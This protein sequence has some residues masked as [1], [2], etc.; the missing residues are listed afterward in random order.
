MLLLLGIIQL[1]KYIASTYQKFEKLYNMALVRYNK[2]VQAH[3]FP[4]RVEN[5]LDC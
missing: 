3:R 4:Q 2:V 1:D 5:Y